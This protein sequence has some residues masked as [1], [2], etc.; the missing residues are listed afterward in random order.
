MVQADHP[1]TH[2]G[3][4]VAVVKPLTGDVLLEDRPS[5]P[6]IPSAPEPPR[7]D[8]PESE[9]QI[10]LS[11]ERPLTRENVLGVRE[12][13]ELPGLPRREHGLQCLLDRLPRMEP[14]DRIRYERGARPW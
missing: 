11:E 4:H 12:V 10:R 6:E 13:A 3:L 9:G 1:V 14:D 8:D 7:P 5:P 2:V